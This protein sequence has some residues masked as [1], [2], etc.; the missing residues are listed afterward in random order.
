V[1]TPS[2]TPG[3]TPGFPLPLRN[4]L[5]T[6]AIAALEEDDAIA[7]LAWL[8]RPVGD[9][10]AAARIRLVA[11]HLI[12]PDG[13]TL[14]AVHG[15][16]AE[17]VAAHAAHALMAAA[18]HQR[19]STHPIARAVGHAVALW[20]QGLFFEVHEVLEDV[21]KTAT[22]DHRQALQGVIQIAVA[23]HHL[24]HGNLRG[25]RSLLREGRARLAS[26]GPAA[27]PVLD[28]GALAAATGPWEDA[29]VAGTPLPAGGRPPALGQAN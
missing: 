26:V 23:F 25:A 6:L 8:A 4:A 11:V 19:T 21:W 12:D 10:P 22:G 17:A 29:L 20:N 24:A 18:T 13:R 1:V 9:P 2:V 28:L 15:P 14:L 3:V 7:A 27:L 5:A 16:H